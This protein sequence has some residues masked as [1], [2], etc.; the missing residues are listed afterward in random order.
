M[1]F[2]AMSDDARKQ[3]LDDGLHLTQQGYDNLAGF[4]AGAINNNAVQRR[5]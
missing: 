3:W 4:I 5:H 1:D 2:Y